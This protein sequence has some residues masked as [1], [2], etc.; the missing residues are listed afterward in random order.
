MQ[1]PDW[2]IVP[3]GNLGHVTAIGKG[4]E[5]LK[6]L[7]LI[8]RLPRL[9][10]AQAAAAAPLYAA[11]RNGWQFQAVKAQP[12]QASA[13]RIG[14]P[15]NVHKAMA[16]LQRFEGVVEQSS[17][18]EITAAWTLGDR[19][20]LYADPH[21]GVA[22][23]ALKHLG[24]QRLVQ[25]GERVVVISTAHGLKFGTL[26]RTHHLAKEKSASTNPPLSLSARLD[27]LETALLPL[28]K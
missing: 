4:F 24:R 23:S 14:A 16:I 21:T 18:E 10:V 26:K 11:Y 7:G 15:V 2:V 28:L 9:C 17:E 12:T 1:P 25:P 20:G 19:H 6:T 3:G 13:I 22:L 5:L 8:D 27:A